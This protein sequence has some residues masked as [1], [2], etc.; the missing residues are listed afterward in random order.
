MMMMQE[1]PAKQ[2]HN[3]KHETLPHILYGKLY[4]VNNFILKPTYMDR[5]KGQAMDWSLMA[6][7][8]VQ[9]S[10]CFHRPHKNLQTSFQSSY[11]TP[12]QNIVHQ[13]S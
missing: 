6:T 12:L 5:R 7:Q 1:F 10:S 8:H 11:E 2:M 4:P 13:N 3:K 9:Q